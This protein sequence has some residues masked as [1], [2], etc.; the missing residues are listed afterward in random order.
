MRLTGGNWRKTLPGAL[1]WTLTV[2]RCFNGSYWAQP[3]ADVTRQ[4]IPWLSRINVFK[5]TN[6][7]STVRRGFILQVVQV[8]H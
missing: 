3:S 5:A 4:T 2:I 8:V 6:L 1:L 7:L